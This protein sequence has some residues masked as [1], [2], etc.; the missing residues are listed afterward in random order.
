MVGDL[1]T[2]IHWIV[3]V[4]VVASAGFVQA[5]TSFDLLSWDVELRYNVA[6]NGTV[7]GFE[8]VAGTYETIIDCEGDDWDLDTN[9]TTT[10]LDDTNWVRWGIDYTDGEVG[11]EEQFNG[12]VRFKVVK[13]AGN[14]E[15]V[16][17]VDLTGSG[18]QDWIIFDDPDWCIGDEAA[19]GDPRELVEYTFEDEPKP[20]QQDPHPADLA[21][22]TFEVTTL[23]DTYTTTTQIPETDDDDLTGLC[24]EAEFASLEA[25]RNDSTREN[26]PFTGHMHFGLE[27]HEG[28]TVLH[29]PT[30]PTDDASYPNAQ[31]L[32]GEIWREP[33]QLAED[34][35][36][37]WPDV[38]CEPGDASPAATCNWDEDVLVEGFDIDDG[39]TVPKIGAPLGWYGT[40]VQERDATCEVD[41]CV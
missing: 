36:D 17:P 41:R 8:E 40:Q 34:D 37:P 12:T 4:M 24:I 39:G 29:S 3:A 1:R 33:W 5:A 14:F 38:K 27:T 31:I 19:A 20:D 22:K 15:E 26:I 13:C 30:E 16:E 28:P 23:N 9:L 11:F 35:P 21:P 10:T 32:A 7:T 25:F 18:H 6:S 2:H